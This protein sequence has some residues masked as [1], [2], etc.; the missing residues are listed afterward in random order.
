ML[1]LVE[2]HRRHNFVLLSI[3]LFE[4]SLAQ[5]HPWKGGEGRPVFSWLTCHPGFYYYSLQ[6]TQQKRPR[7]VGRNSHEGTHFARLAVRPKAALTPLLLRSAHWAGQSRKVQGTLTCDPRA[8]STF[9]RL[10]RHRA[11]LA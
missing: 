1:F 9:Y 7:K 10:P 5:W 2:T 6:I 4:P 8:C 3:S 11:A